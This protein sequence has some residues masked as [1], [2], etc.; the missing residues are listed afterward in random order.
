MS[1]AEVERFSKELKANPDLLAENRKNRLEAAVEVA[2]QRG[3]SFTL[4]EAKAFIRNKARAAGKEL[5]DSQL[6]RVTGGF[7]SC[8]ES[9]HCC[10]H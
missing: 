3:Y 9:I 6:D 5:S 8:M 4:D 2:A 10:L 1:L 7:G